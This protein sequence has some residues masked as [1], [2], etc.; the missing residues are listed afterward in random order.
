MG[1][2]ERIREFGYKGIEM[3]ALLGKDAAPVTGYLIRAQD[4]QA[5]MERLL[6]PLEVEA[7]GRDLDN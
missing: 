3:A 7:S 1:T 6:L 2:R 4:L 5:Q